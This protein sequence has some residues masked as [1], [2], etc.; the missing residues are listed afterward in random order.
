MGMGSC[1]SLMALAM[2]GLGRTTREKV[3]HSWCLFLERLIGILTSSLDD[4]LTL[5]A[6]DPVWS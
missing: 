2:R 4:P 5:R 1:S 3:R 6:R